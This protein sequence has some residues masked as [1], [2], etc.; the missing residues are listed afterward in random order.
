MHDGEMLLLV[1][2][3]D[4]YKDAENNLIPAGY[5]ERPYQDYEQ[6]R[7]GSARNTGLA[8]N[9]LKIKPPMQ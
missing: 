2:A 5:T 1:D 8:Y 3:H 7:Y 4:S 6:G 9:Y